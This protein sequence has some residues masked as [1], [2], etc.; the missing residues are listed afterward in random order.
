MPLGKM[1][2][3]EVPG[4]WMGDTPDLFHLQLGCQSFMLKFLTETGSEAPGS[5]AKDRENRPQN[6]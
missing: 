1:I 3:R 6:R 5:L 4:S 2:G